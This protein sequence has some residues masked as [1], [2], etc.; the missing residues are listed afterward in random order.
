MYSKVNSYAR[1]PVDITG[2]GL[3]TDQLFTVRLLCNSCNS[4]MTVIP[5]SEH[6]PPIKL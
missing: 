4:Q 3:H 5:G 6:R 1:D 2:V